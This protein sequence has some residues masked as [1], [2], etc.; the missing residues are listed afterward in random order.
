M[1]NTN[2][3]LG[4]LAGDHAISNPEECD[5]RRRNLA[6]RLLLCSRDELR[7]IDVILGRLELGRE[8]YGFLDL[9]KARDWDLQEAEELLDAKVYRACAKIVQTDEEVARILERV[10][11]ESTLPIAE[12]FDLG[13]ES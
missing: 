13:G 1:G 12:R 8:R 11:T 10:E 7:V 2:D 6:G 3:Q 4:R 5:A 9:S